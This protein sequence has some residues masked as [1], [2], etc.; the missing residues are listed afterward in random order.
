[1]TLKLPFSPPYHWP[2]MLDFLR[3]RA[4][5]GVEEV[6]DDRYR[7]TFGLPDG[8]GLVD[9]RAARGENH[10]LATIHAS[11]VRVLTSVV[12][13]LRRLFDLDADAAAIDAHLG[14]D[15]R[16]A[17]KLENDVRERPGVRVPGAWD[18]FE[19]AVR[20][21]LGQQVS[22]A[23]ATTY[24]TRLV[25]THG[26]PLASSFG[27]SAPRP[28]P[29]RQSGPRL[30]FPAPAV[31]AAAELTDLGLTRARAATLRGLASEVDQNPGL[32]AP[33]ETLDESVAALGRLPGIGD[34]TAQ[35]VA[36]RAFG[37]PD[38]FPASDLGLLRALAGKDGR[39]SASGVVRLAEAWRPW[40]AY[41]VIRLWTAV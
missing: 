38:A 32:L 8:E 24:A 6:S 26:R 36:L 9:V 27:S 21:V 10:L 3:V 5:P 30:L 12:V 37:E 34:W 17:R 11:D 29:E 4:I 31:L 14:R 15:R 18:G 19:I 25:A 23:A 39:P 20:A 16:F 13:R 35:Y 33:R 41:A 40:R 2:A 1:V 28:A 7:R 22:V